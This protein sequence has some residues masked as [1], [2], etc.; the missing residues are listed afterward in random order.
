MTRAR[1]T[2]TRNDLES[3]EE[4]RWPLRQRSQKN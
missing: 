2:S 3:I 1:R 4:N